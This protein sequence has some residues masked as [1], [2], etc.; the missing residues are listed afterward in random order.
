MKTNDLSPSAYLEATHEYHDMPLPL[1]MFGD[2]SLFSQAILSGLLNNNDGDDVWFFPNHPRDTLNDDPD[3]PDDEELENDFITNQHQE[4]IRDTPSTKNTALS[5]HVTPVSAEVVPNPSNSL[6]TKSPNF[7]TNPTCNPKSCQQTTKDIVPTNTSQT[8]FP[9]NI[10]PCPDPNNISPT[11]NDNQPS[12]SSPNHFATTPVSHPESPQQINNNEANPH[13][14]QMNN[15]VGVGGVIN[16]IVNDII[17][18]TN[19][20]VNV[21]N[22]NFYGNDIP[23]GDHDLI[24]DNLNGSNDFK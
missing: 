23:T 24:N 3:E 16:N 2:N 11:I 19:I 7:N 18:T 12:I 1:D 10:N 14:N 22:D 4:I 15:Y 21:V 8:V 9:V 20:T 5:V 17:N 6:Q 13:Q